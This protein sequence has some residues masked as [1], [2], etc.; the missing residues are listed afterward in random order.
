MSSFVGK[1]GL[2]KRRKDRVPPRWY[3]RKNGKI[4][5][6]LLLKTKSSPCQREKIPQSFFD[7]MSGER[8]SAGFP[9]GDYIPTGKEN[10]RK[11]I[12]SSGTGRDHKKDRAS[13]SGLRGNGFDKKNNCWGEKTRI[14]PQLQAKK[15][16]H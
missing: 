4:S 1:E 6:H 3:G 2:S 9:R 7:N 13:H 14:N 12:G 16:L 10:G 8:S 15:L 11:S 5:N